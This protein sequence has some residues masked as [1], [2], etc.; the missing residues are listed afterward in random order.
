MTEPGT[1]PAAA[2]GQRYASYAL[3]QHLDAAHHLPA[4][5]SYLVT[6]EDLPAFHAEAHARP[7][8]ARAWLRVRRLRRR[9]RSPC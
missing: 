5:Y 6:R 4:G 2:L 9:R 8:R 7:G 3:R 1:T